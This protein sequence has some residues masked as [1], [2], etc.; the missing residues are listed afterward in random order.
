MSLN[1]QEMKIVEEKS[2]STKLSMQ[3]MTDGEQPTKS[4]ANQH[5]IYENINLQCVVGEIVDFPDL[6]TKTHG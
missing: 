3:Q 6:K 1:I 5:Q 4:T 2:K